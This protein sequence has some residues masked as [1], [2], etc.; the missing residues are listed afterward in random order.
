MN[1]L[2]MD[3]KTQKTVHYATRH[4]I[5]VAKS[6]FAAAAALAHE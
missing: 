4:R 5:N 6:F 1:M 3:G 2:Q